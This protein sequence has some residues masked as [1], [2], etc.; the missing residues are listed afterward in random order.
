MHQKQ[1]NKKND[2]YTDSHQISK[3][4]DK[5]Y[6]AD[7]VFDA[8]GAIVVL[9]S[10]ASLFSDA[11]SAHNACQFF[12]FPLVLQIVFLRKTTNDRKL[13][14]VWKSGTTAKIAKKLV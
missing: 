3:F 10:K 6:G 2:N 14:N 13:E 7:A 8:N 5:N 1:Q 4:D 11:I 12:A 9:D